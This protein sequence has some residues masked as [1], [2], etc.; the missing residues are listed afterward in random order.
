M[1]L[2]YPR[3]STI[4]F[5]ERP[6]AVRA[7]ILI[8]AKNLSANRIR[9]GLKFCNQAT[10][11]LRNSSGSLRFERLAVKSVRHEFSKLP[12]KPV[13]VPGFAFPDHEH[14]ISQLSQVADYTLVPRDIPVDLSFP[15]LTICCRPLR[16]RTARMTVPKTAV[17]EYDFFMPRKHD[18]RL[19]GK[20]VPVKS[21][22]IA[23]TVEK[24]AHSNLG[25]RVAH[26]HAR[27][28]LASLRPGELLR[29]FVRAR[30][31]MPSPRLQLS[32]PK[33]G[34]PHSRSVSRLRSSGP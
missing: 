23:E 14:P 7:S 1:Q 3:I 2:E 19:P 16:T 12:K 26:T 32:P 20:V 8:P 34:E 9:N 10:S 22:A 13:G 18:I 21:K 6:T 33:Q 27:H 17:N 25:S 11:F 15:E 5:S 30:A 29:H 28:Q 31:T 4:P 24:S